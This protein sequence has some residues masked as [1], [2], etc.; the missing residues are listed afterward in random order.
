MSSKE[1]DII[2]YLSIYIDLTQ[3]FR[4]MTFQN[5]L[6]I[7]VSIFCFFL[8]HKALPPCLKERQQSLSPLTRDDTFIPECNPD[9]SYRSRQ[10]FTH[11]YYG[12]QCWCVDQS[13]QEILG[14]RKIDGSHPD[15]KKGITFFSYL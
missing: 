5:N 6:F 7:E 3:N 8:L 2:S 4:P 14:T 15:C 9:G 1:I 11:M 13:G 10:C 12:K